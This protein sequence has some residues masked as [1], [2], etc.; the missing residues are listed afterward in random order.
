LLGSVPLYAT[1]LTLT[2][3]PVIPFIYAGC[4]VM[5]AG[6]ALAF[7]VRRRELWLWLD[8]AGG[9]LHIIPGRE[10]LDRSTRSAL[11]RLSRRDAEGEEMAEA[12]SEKPAKAG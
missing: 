8:R 10:H 12:G 2:R 7:F 11:E 3:N 1:T 5:L 4:A 6:L 9:T